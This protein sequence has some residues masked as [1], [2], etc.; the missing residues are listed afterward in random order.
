MVEGARL[1]SVYRGNSIEGSN[2]S[3]SA[4]FLF[5]ICYYGNEKAHLD[6][7][8]F[9]LVFRVRSAAVAGEEQGE[10]RRLPCSGEAPA[11]TG[12]SDGTSGCGSKCRVGWWG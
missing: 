12:S 8:G 2:P 9:L 3:L 7:V 11:L 1:E 5:E 4:T 6:E 10:A